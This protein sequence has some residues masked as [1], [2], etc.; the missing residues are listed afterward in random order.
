MTL[1][2]EV[3]RNKFRED[4]LHRLNVLQVVSP[5]LR[6]RPGDIDLLIDHFLDVSCKKLDAPRLQMAPETRALL[7]RYHWPGNIRQLRNV[8]ERACIM[9]SGEVIRPDDLPDAVQ[10]ADADPSFQSPIISLAEVEKMHVLRVLGTLR[11]QQK[12]DG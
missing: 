1:E 7:L 10:G 9:A 12:G 5:P 2:Q 11:R 8:V 3:A 4:F 6:E